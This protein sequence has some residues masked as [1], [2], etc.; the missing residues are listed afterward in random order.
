MW[1]SQLKS[2]QQEKDKEQRE[3]K[4]RNDEAQRQHL[5]NAHAVL[6]MKQEHLINKPKDKESKSG[7]RFS[8]L[9][10]KLNEEEKWKF[11]SWA[12]IVH[13]RIAIDWRLGRANNFA[14]AFKLAY[15]N[16]F[17]YKSA[18]DI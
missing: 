16:L 9:V 12:G 10:E 2:H 15:N 17:E 5:I 14:P 3:L 13:R 11:N 7:N 8:K 18:L 1:F 6:A 4:E